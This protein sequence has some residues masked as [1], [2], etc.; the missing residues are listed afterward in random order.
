[1]KRLVVEQMIV[2]YLLGNLPEAE[3]ER[4]DEMSLTDDVFAARLD[5]A[6]CDL[7]DDYVTGEL[8]PEAVG[9]FKSHYLASP[10][11]REK[12]HFAQT[13]QDRLRH[14]QASVKSAPLKSRVSSFFAIP[15]LPLQWGFAA[16][17]LLMLLMGGYLMLANVRLRNQIVQKEADYRELKQQEGRLQSRMSQRR[18]SRSRSDS[19]RAL[20]Q[21]KIERLEQQLAE[22]GTPEEIQPRGDVKLLAFSLSPQTRGISKIPALIIPEQTDFV[23]LT[24]ELEVNE[25][26]SYQALLKKSGNG[27]IV[28]RS[29]KIKADDTTNSIL[30]GL[31]ANILNVQ[32][33]LV[34]VSG[35]STDGATEIVGGYPFKVVTQ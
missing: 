11:R 4:L 1:M 35:V 10:R 22:R 31:P 23:A 20:L 2:D 27:E 33:Y 28:W 7:V 6:E 18:S 29:G 30:I 16:A 32:N 13:F 21:Q 5:A 14:E 8:S 12:V 25:F 34:E 26:S 19:E 3:M 24:L 17:A 15:R 9:Q